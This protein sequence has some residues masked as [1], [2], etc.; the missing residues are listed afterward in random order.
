LVLINIDFDKSSNL[1][2][3]DITFAKPNPLKKRINLNDAI[4]IIKI[5]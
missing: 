5:M 4:L 3:N 1:F 2:A